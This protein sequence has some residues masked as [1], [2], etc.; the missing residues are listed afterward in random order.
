MKTANFRQGV[1]DFL[2]Y[3]V[4]EVLLIVFGAE[5]REG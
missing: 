2:G 3:T 4:S 1:K 5:I